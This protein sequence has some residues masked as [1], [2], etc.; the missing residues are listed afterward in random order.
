MWLGV[1]GGGGGGSASK[2]SG[3][4]C[5]LK[6]DDKYDDR[7]KF[8]RKMGSILMETGSSACELS[9]YTTDT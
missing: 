7:Y 6:K 8:L 4:Y 3:A 2:T 1:V 9:I 5:L